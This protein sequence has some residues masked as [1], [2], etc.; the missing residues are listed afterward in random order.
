MIEIMHYLI[1]GAAVEG[2]DAMGSNRVLLPDFLIETC[3][4]D[5]VSGWFTG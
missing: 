1:W 4:L 5:N 3:R 2:I